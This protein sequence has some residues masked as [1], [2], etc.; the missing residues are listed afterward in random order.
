MAAG[1]ACE[2]SMWLLARCMHPPNEDVFAVTARCVSDVAEESEGKRIRLA[3]V[4]ASRESK[5]A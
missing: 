2:D 4:D 1:L 3:T 5:K